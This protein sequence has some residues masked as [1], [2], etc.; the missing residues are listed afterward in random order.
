MPLENSNYILEGGESLKLE[1]RNQTMSEHCSCIIVL[2][3][4]VL[5]REGL[6]QAGTTL[7]LT[8]MNICKTHKMGADGPLVKL[9]WII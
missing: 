8:L 2:L 9:L 3:K 7:K 6:Y 1:C 4:N 5:H